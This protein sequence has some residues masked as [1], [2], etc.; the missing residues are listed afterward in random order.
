[1]LVMDLS[2]PAGVKVRIP[3]A[4]RNSRVVDYYVRNG[5]KPVSGLDE[6]AVV[7]QNDYNNMKQDLDYNLEGGDK[8]FAG[9]R[10]FFLH[11]QL[12]VQI[13]YEDISTETVVASVDQSLDGVNW[14][15]IP[16]V[17]QVLDRTKPAHTFNIIGLLTDFVRLHV[18]VPDSSQGI[19]RSVTWKT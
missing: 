10:L 6:E 1:S 4:V 8:E 16:Y 18:A 2:V 15:T 7:T 13:A 5:I 9:V 17:N 3:Q 11:D 14:T 12:S 19:I